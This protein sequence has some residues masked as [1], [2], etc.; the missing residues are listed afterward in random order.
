MVSDFSLFPILKLGKPGWEYRKATW[1]E[2][3][4]EQVHKMFDGI[5]MDA[6]NYDRMSVRGNKMQNCKICIVD[7]NIHVQPG[8]GFDYLVRRDSLINKEVIIDET[9]IP[10]DLKCIICMTNKKVY[11]V[12]E[13]GHV[14]FCQTCSV[15]VCKMTD[16]CPVCRTVIKDKF[17]RLFF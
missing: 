3:I 7:G 14:L 4:E 9:D 5:S 2:D 6:I 12:K 15:D 8:D 11:A 16:T 1:P 13:C 10:Y 17:I